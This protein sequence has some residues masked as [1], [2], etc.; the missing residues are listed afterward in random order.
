MKENFGKIFLILVSNYVF[1]CEDCNNCNKPYVKYT[2]SYI[3]NI[4]STVTAFPP[5]LRA[6]FSKDST[7]CFSLYKCVSSATFGYYFIQLLRV[8]SRFMIF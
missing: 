4:S 2:F 5:C 7:V 6:W 1:W 3:Y 8:V